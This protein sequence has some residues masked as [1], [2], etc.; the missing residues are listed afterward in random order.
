MINRDY[1][2]FYRNL[3]S[4][5]I[6]KAVGGFYDEAALPSYTH[7]EKNSLILHPPAHK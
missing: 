1:K 2:E 3:F 4:E 7:K 5:A 6:S